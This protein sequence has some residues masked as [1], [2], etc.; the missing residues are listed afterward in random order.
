MDLIARIESAFDTEEQK[1]FLASFQSHVHHA[2]DEFVIDFNEI[3]QWM[4]FTRNENAKRLLEKHFTLDKDFLIKLTTPL[5]EA[6]LTCPQHGGQNKGIFMMSLDMFETF[7][8]RIP[9][10]QK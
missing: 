8:M 4:G 5:H 7:C 2:P 6:T 3:W 10:K 1:L 9:Q